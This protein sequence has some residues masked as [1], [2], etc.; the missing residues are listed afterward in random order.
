MERYVLFVNTAADYLAYPLKSFVG[1]KYAS[2]TTIDLFFEK[3]PLAYKITL[4]INTGTGVQTAKKLIELFSKYSGSVIT[5]D[6]EQGLFPC[7]DITAISSFTKVVI[8]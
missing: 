1:I 4:T 3:A 5:F 7:A 8:K 6:E 2:A